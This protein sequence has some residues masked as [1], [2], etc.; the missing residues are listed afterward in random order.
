MSMNWNMQVAFH[1]ASRASFRVPSGIEAIHSN[2]HENG[3]A[4]MM[5]SGWNRPGN[6]LLQQGK[7]H[8]VPRAIT[9]MGIN[10]GEVGPRHVATP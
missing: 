5:K 9:D 2:V 8:N 10:S 7:G 6:A 1:V 4:M 3:W